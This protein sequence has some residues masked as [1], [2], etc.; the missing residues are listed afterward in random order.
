[1]SWNE[2]YQ[3]WKRQPHL[4]PELR[5]E[6]GEMKGDEEALKDAFEAPMSFGTAGMRGVMGAGIGLMNIYTVGA[7]TE[8]LARFMDTLS[9]ADKKRGVA[10]GFDSRYHS[11]E[12][13]HRVAKVLGAHGI[14]SY[15]FDDIRPT[16]ELSF[17]VRY[18][19]TF[20]GV[21]I[22]ASHN[23]K[24]Y[25]GYKLYG[26]DGGQMAPDALEKIVDQINSVTDLFSE[27]VSSEQVLRQTN[28]MH[29]IGEDVDEPYLENVASVTINH[30]LIESVGSQMKL[31]YTPLH[32]T[33]RVI[34]QR[35]LTNAGFRQFKMVAKQA[36]ADPE[37]PT[38]PYPN[39]EFSQAFDMAIQLGKE[40]HADL[41]VATDPDADRLGAAVRQPDGEYQLMTG[42]QIASVLLAYILEAH[43]Q[44]GDLPANGMVVKSIVS[45]ELATK[46]ANDYGVEM[47]DVLTGF[48]YIAE[49]IKSAEDK[50]DKTF[51]FGFEESYGYLIKPF[52]RDKDAIQS[53]LLLAEVAA[54]Y[55]QQGLTLYDGIQKLYQKYG[56]YAEKT[57]AQ[58]YDGV[59]GQTIMKKIMTKVH[60]Q[61]PTS[62]AG[63][64]VQSVDDILK[65]VQVSADG[66]ETALTLPKADV[67]KYW[68]EDGTWIAVRPSGTEPKIKL[69]I[70]TNGEN[71]A[72]ADAKLANYETS[73]KQWISGI[74]QT[75]K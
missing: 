40:E 27:K 23:P 26:E 8:G 19:H 17:A 72:D 9:A 29:I 22:T 46:I 37:F 39:P 61:Q 73:L 38:T 34:G 66:S 44:A 36:I 32:G 62:F 16:P 69:Y 63:V 21:M 24:Q 1:M 52:V 56:F 70:G 45:T 14:P 4:Q 5:A 31:V 18:L 53:T 43:K 51:L 58:E 68:L 60:E 2:N 74:E 54:Y 41:L 50:K 3:E 75:I 12:F 71:Q 10:V 7:A 35:A 57:I 42:N 64:N 28:L 49:Q 55:K 20:A 25:N 33:G 65:G 15:V 59:K 47:I 30:D 13:A 67:L 48:K 11:R 6:L